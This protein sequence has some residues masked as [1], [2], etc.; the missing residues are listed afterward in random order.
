MKNHKINRLAWATLIAAAAVGSIVAQDADPVTQKTQLLSE[1]LAAREKGDLQVALAKFEELQKISADDEAAKEGIASVKAAL[2]AAEKAKADEEAAKAKAAAPAPAAPAKPASLLDE[3]ASGH[4]NLYREVAQAIALAKQTADQGDYAGALKILDGA[5]GA[6]PNNIAAQA[7]R[8]EVTLAKQE[9]VSRRESG[10]QGADQLARAEVVRLAKVNAAAIDEASK[11]IDEAE[12]SVRKGDLDDANALLD[13]ASSNLPRNIATQ[14]VSN[15]IKQV[16]S[17]I[18]SRRAFLAMDAREMNKADAFVRE[19]ERLN[20]ADDPSARRLRAEF[21][22]KKSDPAF[23]SVDEISPGL[24]AKDDKVQELLVK[25]RARYLYGDYAGAL[26]AYREILQYQPNNAESKA[27][28]VRIRQVLSENSGQWN[29]SVTKGKLLELLD[30][31]WKLPEVYN[32]EV[33]GVTGPVTTDPILDKLR[34]ITVPEINIRDL[35]FDRAIAQLT[36]VSQ[37]YDK[38]NKGVNMFVIDPDRKNPSVNMT[39]RNVTLEKAID[40]ITKQVNFTYTINAGI[41]EIRPDSGSNDLETEFFPLSSAAETKMTGIGT[42]APATT[43]PGATASPFGGATAGA[44]ATDVN[45]RNEGI[46]NFLTRSGVSFEVTGAVLNYDGTT[47]IV[48]QNRK[49]LERIRNILRR[50]S[51]IKQVHIESK[52]I[53]VSEASLNEL[54]TNLRLSTKNAAGVETIRAQTN[55]RSVNDVFGSSVVSNPGSITSPGYTTVATIGGVPITQT[56]DPQMTT[57]SNTPPKF[58]T[59]NFG[60]AEPNF[61]GAKGWNGAVGGY[62]GMI[63]TIGSYDLSIFLKAIEQN[64]GSDLMSAPSLTVLDGK[65]A[66]IKIAQL[67]RYPQSYGDTQS[68]VGST[69]GGNNNGG[70]SAGVT[71]TAGTPQDFTVQEVGVTLEVTPTVGADDSIA[72]NL[73]PKVTEFEGFVEYGGTSVAI[74]AGTTVTI[75]SGF[76]Q[77]IFTTREVSTDVT[78]FD[79]ATVV[80][81][82]LTREEVKTVN[83]KVPVLGDIPLLGAAFRSSGKSTTK[84]NLTVFV[85]ANLVSPGGATLRSSY[86]GMRAGSVFQNPVVLSP[87]GAVYREPVEAATTPASPRE[88]APAA[89]AA[90][91]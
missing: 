86:P 11:F 20:G 42:G 10:D 64:S 7:W 71:I 28:Q 49:N 62:N 73:K 16:R 50:Y 38:E 41:I 4:E 26:D 23:R 13:K 68:N 69:G 57:I 17:S 63:G 84:K 45:P 61:G 22:A 2:A 54:S 24:R 15:R 9:I 76:F 80:I 30:E 6:L 44:G 82:G 14:P 27:F 89:P 36:I 79:G 85:T 60:G 18:I 31:S 48:T 78:V 81:G 46:K 90:G 70:G 67:L 5:N 8:D 65:T 47:L 32:R 52:F 58:P 33:G 21:A 91:Q 88:A 39:L 25:G 3:V 87:G 35:P 59:G 75:P 77:P 19:F 1:A 40:L 37:S 53:E 12:S 66:I 55:L 51:D 83:D 74:S 56:V 72:L 34:S 29:R 43:T